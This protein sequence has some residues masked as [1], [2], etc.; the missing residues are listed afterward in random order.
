MK[1]KSSL[2]FTKKTDTKR[3]ISQHASKFYTLIKDFKEVQSTT[4]AN[5][6]QHATVRLSILD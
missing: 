6:K 5:S 1:E 2:S 4:L 3:P